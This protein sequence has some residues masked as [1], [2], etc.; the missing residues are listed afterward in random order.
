[1]AMYVL[2]FLQLSEHFHFLF[3]IEKVCLLYF[4]CSIPQVIFLFGLDSSS[5]AVIREVT[6]SQLNK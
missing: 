4:H 1:M 2:I 3:R 6:L 5:T